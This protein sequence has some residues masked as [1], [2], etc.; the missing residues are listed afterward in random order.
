VAYGQRFKLPS[1]RDNGP[2]WRDRQG[3]GGGG[4]AEFAETRIKQAVCGFACQEQLNI[5]GTD[6]EGKSESETTSWRLPESLACLPG[7]KASQEQQQQPEEEQQ[8][9]EEEQEPEEA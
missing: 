8:R 2:Q 6:V 5:V 4:D 7:P 3:K 9:E 1:H